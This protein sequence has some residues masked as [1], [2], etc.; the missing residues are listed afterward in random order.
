MTVG[1]DV[2]VRILDRLRAGLVDLAIM[3]LPARGH[4]LECFPLRTERLFAILPKAPRLARKRHVRMKELREE[5]FLLLRDDHCFRDTTIQVCKR[6]SLMPRIDSERW[7]ARR[8]L[9]TADA[10]LGLTMV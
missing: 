2:T 10:G 8:S 3:A 5:P 4:E 9:G 1:E 7:R 6:A